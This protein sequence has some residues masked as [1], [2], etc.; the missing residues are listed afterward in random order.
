M[1][2]TDFKLRSQVFSSMR[3]TAP[4]PGYTAGQMVK[5]E[6]TVGVI[7]EAADT[8]DE[9][10]LVYK[11]EKIVVPKDITSGQNTFAAGDKVYF[12]ATDENVNSES[13]GNTLCGRALEAAVAA[14]TE[15]LIELDGTSA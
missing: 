13:S 4:S 5:I 7:V 14:D 15:V 8:G 12:D 11:A 3:V 1:A 10:V 2:E 9:A 6:D